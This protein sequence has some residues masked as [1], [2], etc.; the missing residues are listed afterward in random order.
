MLYNRLEIIQVRQ[1]GRESLLAELA[2]SRLGARDFLV[3][4]E[5][6]CRFIDEVGRG[7][8]GVVGALAS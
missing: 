1:S 2:R 3:V 4:L 5:L 7:F 8:A 6:R